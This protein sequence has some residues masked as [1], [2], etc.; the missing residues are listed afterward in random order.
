MTTFTL[1]SP[2]IAAGGSIAPVFESDMFGCGGSNQSPVLQWSGAPPL[3]MPV[4]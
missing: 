3:P 1:S 2:D 4:H